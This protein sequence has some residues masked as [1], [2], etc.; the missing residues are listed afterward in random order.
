MRTQVGGTMQ[1]LPGLIAQPGPELVLALV[2]AVG[3]DL[4]V[5]SRTLQEQLLRVNYASP[6]WRSL[7]I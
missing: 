4:A 5:V 6:K 1:T 7:A 2:G 3:T